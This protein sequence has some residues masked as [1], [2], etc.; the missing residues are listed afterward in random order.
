MDARHVPESFWLDFERVLDSIAAHHQFESVHQAVDAMLRIYIARNGEYRTEPLLRA[1]YHANGNSVDWLLTITS[2]AS[3][4]RQVLS[5]ILPNEWNSHGKWLEVP[6]IVRIDRRIVELA[7][8]TASVELSQPDYVFDS[9]RKDYVRALLKEKQIAEAS[10][11]LSGVAARERYKSDWLPL[12]LAVADADGSLPQLLSMWEREPGEAPADGELRGASSRLPAASA[13]KVQRFV[14]QR[15]LD[16]RD[17][18]AANF[19]GLA[20][21]DLEESNTAGAVQ[22]LRRLTLVS[23]SFYSDTDAAAKLLEEHHRPA[24]AIAFLKPLA[25]ASPWEIGYKVRLAKATLDVDVRSAD[26]LAMLTAAAGDAKAAYGVRLLAAEALKGHSAGNGAPNSGSDEL[27]LLAQEGCPSAESAS[28]P[29]FVAARVAA[30]ACA[31][32]VSVKERLLHEALEA[33]PEDV[34]V[35]RAYIFAAFDANF[36]SRAMVAAEKY[37]E[38]AY[39]SPDYADAGADDASAGGTSAGDASDSG[40]GSGDANSQV[41]ASYPAV[42]AGAQAENLSALPVAQAARLIRLAAAAYE[43]RHDYKSALQLLAQRMPEMSSEDRKALEEKKQLIEL[44]QARA[45]ANDAR[46]PDIHPELDQGRIVRPRLLPG[47]A[48]PVQSKSSNEEE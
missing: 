24:E 45:Q 5:S 1:G 3:D 20:A 37:L 44:L 33:A 48:V 11:F 42:R 16:R 21:I 22:L 30:A 14:Y 25:D 9:A 41:A 27:V 38:S 12:A 18:S 32:Q 8:Q 10:A 23:D 35:R 19:L 4:Q 13:R 26:A 17:L 15:A 28:K 6:Q 34:S 40:G 7:Q 29:L 2:A 31:Q 36:D 47:M 43:R 46:A 39:Y